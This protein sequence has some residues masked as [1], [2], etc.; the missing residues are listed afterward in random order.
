[1][2]DLAA[3]L[4][5]L[6]ERRGTAPWPDH[7][8]V[9]GWGVMGLPLDSGHYLALRV[10]PENDFSPY[11]TL[12]HRDPDGRWSIHVDG[13]RRCRSERQRYEREDAAAT[14]DVEDRAT[15]VFGIMRVEHVGDQRR[16]C[17]QS[18]S[19]RAPRFELE[20]VSAAELRRNLA[21]RRLD[22][23]PRRQSE[24]LE[25]LLPGVTPRIADDLLEPR[26]E[27]RVE[28]GDRVERFLAR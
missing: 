24:R 12:W 2:T 5:D 21:P 3:T 28:R 18:C 1:M 10:F 11:K 22:H 14:T 15:C 16:G 13:A 17:V 27:L 7:E 25:V 19:E 26:I 23:D 4:A 9:K 6:P 8:Y 20:D